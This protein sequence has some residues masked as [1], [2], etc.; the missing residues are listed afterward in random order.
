MSD[1]AHVRL[2]LIALNALP[3]AEFTATVGGV[4]EHSP[5][6]SER[7]AEGRPFASLEE[8]H[9]ALMAEV[10]R[11][12]EAEKLALLRAHPDLADR[13]LKLTTASTGEQASAGLNAL[14]TEQLADFQRLNTA[15]RERFGFPF[16]ICA[17]MN[18]K[19]AILTAFHTRLDN[20][21]EQEFATALGEVSK[22]ARLRLADLI[23]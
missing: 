19:E 7:A 23:A 16:I 22:I 18:S 17:R 14:S 1:A 2:S 13:L 20:S 8:I 15:Y 11:A 21:R 9:R 10:E 6:F 12:P 3:P 4:L 5:H